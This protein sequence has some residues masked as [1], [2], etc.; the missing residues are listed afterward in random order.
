MANKLTEDLAN[1][2]LDEM[3]N[4]T[5]ADLEVRSDYSGRGMYGTEVV[6]FVFDGD[7]TP[8]LIAMGYA[9]AKLQE[10]YSETWDGWEPR[11]LPR[12]MDSM[13]LGTVIY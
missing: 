10:D 12:R 6:A 2:L 13:G 11:D 7:A 3:C 9:L 5:N 1:E 8:V 4:W